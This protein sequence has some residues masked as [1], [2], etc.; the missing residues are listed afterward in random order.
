MRKLVADEIKSEIVRF[1]LIGL[2]RDRIAANLNIG[3]GTVSHEISEW[4]DRMGIPTAEALR[5]FSILL[6]TLNVTPLQCADGF[7]FSNQLK[8]CG[9]SENEIMPLIVGIYNKCISTNVDPELLFHVCKQ[10]SELRESVSIAELPQF[11][12]K[13]VEKKRSLECDLATIQEGKEN[14]QK[15]YSELFDQFGIARSDLKKY[16]ETEQKLLGY[17]ISLHDDTQ[18]FVNV[19]D[20]LD[21]SGSDPREIAK[22]LAEIKNCREE[23]SVL[24]HKLADLRSALNKKGHE[25][26]IVEHV[27]ASR[28]QSLTVYS[29]LEKLGI[30]LAGLHKLRNVVLE[31]AA[32]NSIDP[33]IAFRRF[34]K[35]VLTN[36]DTELGIV[37]KIEGMTNILSASK[38]KHDSLELEYSKQRK[39]YDQAAE[40]FEG[41][42][43]AVDIVQINEVVKASGTG[44]Q[45][46]K[47]DLEHYG[48]L[49]NALNQI[50]TRVKNL[51]SECR[52]LLVRANCLRSEND[53]V[54][55]EIRLGKEQLG[56]IEM[57]FRKRMDEKVQ[58]VGMTIQKIRTANLVAEERATKRINFLEANERQQLNLLQKIEVPIQLSPII[59]AA[60]GQVVDGE[61]LRK[62]VTK[63]MELMILR[64]DEENNR[65]VKSDMQKA[66]KTLRSEF[67]VF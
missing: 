33:A 39:I 54:A 31:I 64:L 60:R 62:A 59:E 14:L 49:A 34:I 28:K 61:A 26:Q 5:D 29:E 12:S 45:H 41:G 1:W 42:V 24:Q 52:D 6:R 30:G 19:L 47:Q 48:N 65:E 3:A 20:N 22:E 10:I 38:H 55:K 4:K 57:H 11:I 40:L 16:K 46:V 18:K 2:Q 15:E 58:A 27:L 35:D 50:E 32:I 56:L 21:N 51:R 8:R 23:I 25:Y 63:S 9:I 13:Q 43:Q 7:R 17:G 36:Y 67:I 37:G 66:L 53:K 44:F